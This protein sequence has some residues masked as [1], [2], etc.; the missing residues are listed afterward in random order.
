MVG[1]KGLEPS[2]SLLGVHWNLSPACLPFHHSP[3]LLFL[4]PVEAASLCGARSGAGVSDFALDLFLV[5]GVELDGLNFL[6][7]HV[8]LLCVRYAH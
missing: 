3:M 5:N 2:R 1:K 8:T 4:A 7:G 6:L